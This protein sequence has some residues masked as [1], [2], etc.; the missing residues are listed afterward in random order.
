VSRYIFE[1]VIERMPQ[2]YIQH[3]STL[4]GKNYRLPTTEWCLTQ[5]KQSIKSLQWLYMFEAW[6]NSRLADNT[7]H[8]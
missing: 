4:L 6:I 7:N 3:F 2:L 1:Y 5:S 8:S